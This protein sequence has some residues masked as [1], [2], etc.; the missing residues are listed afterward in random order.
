MSDSE[1][2]DFNLVNDDSGSASDGYSDSPKVVKK[3]A[4]PKK[5][6]AGP[7]KAVKVNNTLL[8]VYVYG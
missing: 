4:A 5:A 1:S 8:L 7:S 2:E 3:A 6:V